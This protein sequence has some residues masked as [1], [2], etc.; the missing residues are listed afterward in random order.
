MGKGLTAPGAAPY[1]AWHAMG[2]STRT[3]FFY[4]YFTPESAHRL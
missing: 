2:T 3:R 1:I 4:F